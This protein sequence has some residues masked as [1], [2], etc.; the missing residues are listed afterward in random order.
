V[1]QFSDSVDEVAG[2]DAEFFSGEFG[3]GS[4]AN[5]TELIIFFQRSAALCAIRQ[6]FSPHIGKICDALKNIAKPL[7]ECLLSN[8]SL[9]S[10]SLAYA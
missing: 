4:A 2:R 3:Y 7:A 8:A 1:Q 5:R 6:A 10:V 9:F